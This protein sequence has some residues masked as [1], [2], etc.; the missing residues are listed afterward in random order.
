APERKI[1]ALEDPEPEFL[2][3]GDT[4]RLEGLPLVAVLAG[5]ALVLPLVDS[6]AMRNNTQVPV[7]LAA[8]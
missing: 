3:C 5:S 8:N 1:Q 6:L 7:Q 2:D 4:G